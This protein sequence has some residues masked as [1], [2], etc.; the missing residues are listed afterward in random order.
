VTRF[1]FTVVPLLLPR[2]LTC[3]PSG[4]GWNEAWFRETPAS[5]MQTSLVVDRPTVTEA[6]PSSVTSVLPWNR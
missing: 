1:P 2:S 3:H 4:V 5:G 6:V